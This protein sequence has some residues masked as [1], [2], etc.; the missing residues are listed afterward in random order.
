MSLCLCVGSIGFIEPENAKIIRIKNTKDLDKIAVSEASLKNF[1]N[2]K[3]LKQLCFDKNGNLPLID[4]V[5]KP[6]PDKPGWEQHHEC[7]ELQRLLC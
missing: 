6:N 4:S 5:I 3:D 7:N 1:D 2:K